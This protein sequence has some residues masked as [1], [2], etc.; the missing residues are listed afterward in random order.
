MADATITQRVEAAR[1]TARY[2]MLAEASLE[3]HDSYLDRLIA[4]ERAEA[5][6]NCRNV[7]DF[8]ACP[9]CKDVLAAIEE[10]ERV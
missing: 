10:I 1:L 2:K 9:Y 4:L 3:Q 8:R 5:R 6:W 7:T